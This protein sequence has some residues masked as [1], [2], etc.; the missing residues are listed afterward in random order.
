MRCHLYCTTSHPLL[1]ILIIVRIN[2]DWSADEVY[3]LSEL[4]MEIFWHSL[5]QCFREYNLA[6]SEEF[7]SSNQPHFSVLYFKFKRPPKGI[8]LSD[9]Q[10]SKITRESKRRRSSKVKPFSEVRDFEDTE[11]LDELADFAKQLCAVA[12]RILESS[13]FE[14]PD[15]VL[16]N[17]LGKRK[18][19]KG[20]RCWVVIERKEDAGTRLEQGR[21]LHLKIQIRPLQ[22]PEEWLMKGKREERWWTE[23]KYKEKMSVD[24]SWSMVIDFDW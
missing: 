16:E 3:D 10:A 2:M 5:H 7:S 21:N 18:Y 14:N 4:Y 12:D 19:L 22:P 24:D 13:P 6:F 9:R 23:S 11:L 8:R 17:E 20:N 1:T 15:S